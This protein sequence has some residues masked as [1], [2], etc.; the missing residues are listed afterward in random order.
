MALANQSRR[1]YIDSVRAHFPSGTKKLRA[2]IRCRVIMEE[3][4]FYELGCPQC[5]DLMMKEDQPRV[6]ACTTQNFDGFIA[7]IRPGGFATRFTGL[8]NS[9]PGFYALTVRGEIPAEIAFD[10]EGQDL[11][12]FI[13]DGSDSGLEAE[14]FGS[15]RP[16]QPREK[17][18]KVEKKV[19]ERRLRPAPPSRGSG[20]NMS[21]SDDD[22][23]ALPGRMGKFL[24]LS[25]SD[26]D[27][28][29]KNADK[30]L[31]E[32]NDT[33]TAKFPTTEQTIPSP[34][35]NSASD[36]AGASEREKQ[37]SK[38]AS[39]AAE[40]GKSWPTVSGTSKGSVAILEPEGDT[41]FD[42][43]P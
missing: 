23:P 43:A 41:E 24:D 1:A 26:A 8:E 7:N 42:R 14:L 40:S 30:Q 25:D 4:Q 34:D 11:A 37:S 22:G 38:A 39:S 32:S 6:S 9:M 21:S 2:C 29:K 28:P 35:I 33:T 3:T 13:D 10:E 18:R 12:G 36:T 19:V 16:Q 27:T 20:S 31:S 5:P 17:K 15:D